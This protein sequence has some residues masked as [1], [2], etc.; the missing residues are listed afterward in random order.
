MTES[1][2]T[3]EHAKAAIV[4]G[5]S[6]GIGLAIA[7]AL[8]DRGIR[9]CVTGRDA[10]ALAEAA[11][12]LGEGRAIHV[13]GR[14]HDASHQ[15]Q[16]VAETM[17]A[18]GRV[19]YL[20]N[21]VGTNPVFGPVLDLEADVLR[22][23][24]DINVVSAFSWTRRVYQTWMEANGGAIVNVSSVASLRPAPGLGVYGM[25][26]AA[27]GYLTEQLALE[28]GPTVRVNAVAPAV[29]K[30]RFAAALYEGR[31]EEVAAGYPAGRL[32]VPD[33]VASAVAFLLSD[34][35]SWITG[36]TMVLDG[37]STLIGGLA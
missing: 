11:A 3:E 21:N 18:F 33:D 29:V 36:H 12:G 35:A 26:K 30:T 23:V 16:A 4:T 10:D 1:G 37:G 7:Q 2:R 32:G 22:K 25:S 14:A 34:E 27:L 9:V 8:V 24:F 20:V 13:A 19:D 15:E 28:L 5:A 17:R 6:R 31:E